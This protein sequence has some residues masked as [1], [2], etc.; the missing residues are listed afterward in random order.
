MDLMTMSAAISI[1]INAVISET[2]KELVKDAYKNLKNALQQKFGKDS[3]ILEA[4]KKLEED[5]ESPGWKESVQ[6]E[7]GKVEAQ[8]DTELKQLTEM[9]LKAIEETTEGQ[10]A[11][12]KYRI[13]A[14]K[15]GVVGD[16]A[17]ITGGQHF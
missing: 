1:A 5:P 10:K 7:L 3:R 12:K 6:K 15:I 16:H 4:V 17:H 2:G 13:K 14:E 8:K 11:I 9:L